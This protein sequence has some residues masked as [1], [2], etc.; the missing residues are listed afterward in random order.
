ELPSSSD[1]KDLT[2]IE[3]NKQ[4]IDI[5]YYL[6]NLKRVSSSQIL[7]NPFLKIESGYSLVLS[8]IRFGDW[9]AT[10]DE[11][12]IDIK[13]QLQNALI[14]NITLVRV[15][16]QYGGPK[17]IN[18]NIRSLGEAKISN[19][20]V[21]GRGWVHQREIRE[22]Q[23]TDKEYERLGVE[24]EKDKCGKEIVK[25]I[26]SEGEQL[27][28]KDRIIEYPSLVEWKHPSIKVKGGKLR[29]VDSTFVGL[30]VDGALVLEDVDAELSNTTR[31]E[32]NDVLSAAKAGG[33]TKKIPPEYKKVDDEKKN[34][35]FDEDDRQIHE[36]RRYRGY[37]KNLFAK[38]QTTLKAW[39]VS[40]I[41]EKLYKKK[42][43]YKEGYPLLVQHER[44]VKLVGEVG[45]ANN[46]YGVPDVTYVKTEYSKIADKKTADGKAEKTVQIEIRTKGNLIPGVEW[47][48]EL[49]NKKDKEGTER[50]YHYN[51]LNREIWQDISPILKLQGWYVSSDENK[52]KNENQKT[53]S[54]P[55]DEFGG[56][57]LVRW[58][59]ERVIQVRI[60]H[61][62]PYVEKKSNADKVK[63]PDSDHI[64]KDWQLRL[65]V[66]K[67]A[68]QE[69]SGAD[70][71]VKWTNLKK[72]G[73]S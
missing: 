67:R 54:Y 22:I 53:N 48:I 23:K 72:T 33:I 45:Q 50:L 21:D 20:V 52:L 13:G 41:G 38:G 51:L 69:G 64:Y 5:D 63:D 44:T 60:A 40:F 7:I 56:Q 10:S 16:R 58:L 62:E 35:Q 14:E 36:L 19:V 68:D 42:K 34:D 9:I 2:K 25:E 70:P 18:L 49:K 1:R 11:P 59:S 30:G 29:I 26:V 61:I 3:S 47:F 66:E 73:L 71:E 24:A 31:F 12:L 15:G 46:A 4:K 43:A 17:L 8:R 65:G 57:V 6:R 32:E 37:T 27:Q 39:N 28:T 55:A